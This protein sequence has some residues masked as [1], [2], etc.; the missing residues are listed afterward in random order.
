MTFD[1]SIT[2]QPES[3]LDYEIYDHQ[4][5]ENVPS[6]Y[7]QITFY[8][9][10]D[11]LQKHTMFQLDYRLKKYPWDTTLKFPF[12]LVVCTH[13]PATNLE[14]INAKDP[15]QIYIQ[16]SIYEQQVYNTSEMIRNE[17]VWDYTYD[18]A[19]ASGDFCLEIVYDYS[20]TMG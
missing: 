17:L 19:I 12:A 2:D 7:N 15:W 20:T 9:D 11:K 16:R 8:T 5:S 4:W 6:T 3:Y 14:V 18:P 13:T 1:V 10:P